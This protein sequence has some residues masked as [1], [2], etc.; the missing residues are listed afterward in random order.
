MQAQR[1]ALS[2]LTASGSAYTTKLLAERLSQLD[3]NATLCICTVI[4]N[5]AFRSLIKHHHGPGVITIVI[6]IFGL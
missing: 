1:N 6:F 4:L 2:Y 3:R 5:N